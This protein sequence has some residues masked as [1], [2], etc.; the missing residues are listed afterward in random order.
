MT[1][2]PPTD[3]ALA[4]FSLADPP[5]GFVDDPYPWYAA[6]R[7]ARPRHRLAADSVLLTRHDDVLAVYRAPQASSDKTLE[8]AP[9]GRRHADLR[10][11]HHQ[12]GV[13]RP[14]AAHPC[15]PHPDGRAEPAGDH[16][17][18]AGLVRLVDDL[19]DALPAQPAP[20]L[21][22]HFAAQIPVE[23]IGNLLAVPHA[24][25]APLRDWSLAILSALE[26][27]PARPACWTA[28]TPRSWSSCPTCADLLAER[29]RHPGDPKSTC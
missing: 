25:R 4:A 19:L 7:S 5:A 23:V 20:D 9:A 15:A 17:H 18:G 21:I 24:E 11:P 27:A 14:A 13:Q 2:P 1:L 28:P 16:A 10:A 29:R 3:A 26:P 8:F 22:E 12:P 6:L